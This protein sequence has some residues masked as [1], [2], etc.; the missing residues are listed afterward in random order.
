MILNDI[1]RAYSDLEISKRTGV[2][3]SYVYLIR[4][5]KRKPKPVTIEKIVSK[6]KAR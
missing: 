5:G 2:H 3:R 4:T 6:F 1:F